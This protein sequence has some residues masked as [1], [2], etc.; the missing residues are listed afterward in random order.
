MGSHR[1]ARGGCCHLCRPD[2][3]PWPQVSKLF[4]HTSR[5]NTKTGKVNPRIEQQPYM[6]K[7]I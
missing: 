1:L 3:I 4:I 5:G 7:A 2:S 6:K